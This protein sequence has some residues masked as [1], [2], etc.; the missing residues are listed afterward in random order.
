VEQVLDGPNNLLTP[1]FGVVVFLG[2]WIAARPFYSSLFL[3][4]YPYL[5]VNASQRLNPW[6]HNFIPLFCVL[7]SDIYLS[8]VNRC[9]NLFSIVIASSWNSAI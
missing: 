6:K 9:L 2:G 3:L 8:N 5:I 7:F 1:I 4:P